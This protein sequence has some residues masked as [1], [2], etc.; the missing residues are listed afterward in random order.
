MNMTD[1]FATGV[2]A[3]LFLTLYTKAMDNRTARPILGACQADEIVSKLDYN[4]GKFKVT[5]GLVVNGAIRARHLDD[6]VGDFIRHHPTAVVVE[7]G[8]G[9][10]NR[11]SRIPAPASV[12]WFDVDYPDVIEL[13]R[14]FIGEDDA[15]R[16]L[17]A[18]LN[19][20]G[21]LQQIPR[22]RPAIIAAD[23]VTPFLTESANK[24]LFQRL[25][26][27]FASGEIVFN[28]YTTTVVR[29]MKK[30]PTMM[31]I[32]AADGFGFDDP[33]EPERWAPRLKFVEAIALIKT[34]YARQLPFGYRLLFALLKH[35]PWMQ[36]EGG[37]I[38]RYRFP[39]YA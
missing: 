8:C 12:T 30:H 26:S 29:L 31:A 7:I 3:T 36:R 34:P 16:M 20:P 4:F 32:G 38:L 13:R 37:R 9:L 19:D 35:I 6:C 10:D 11:S 5:K 21:W 2:R 33:R 22:D 18:D 15:H 1:R 27:H 23:G 28:G 14:R 39:A 25:T 24:Q 17:G